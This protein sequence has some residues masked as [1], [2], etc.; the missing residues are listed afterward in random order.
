MGRLRT[1]DVIKRNSEHKSFSIHRMVS[2]MIRQRMADQTRPQS[3]DKAVSL[4]FNKFPQQN[5][6]MPLH[7]EHRTCDLYLQHVLKIASH[8]RNSE[9]QHSSEQLVALL[10]NATW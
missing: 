10:H 8:Y 5:M 3:F 9:Q 1:H 2:A 6:G 4:L 7:A